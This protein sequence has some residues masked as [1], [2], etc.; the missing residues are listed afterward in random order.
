MEI[1]QQILYNK[2]CIQISFLKNEVFLLYNLYMLR[3]FKINT[4]L[5]ALITALMA[6]PMCYSASV[7]ARALQMRSPGRDQVI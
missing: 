2:F 7:K 3:S 6:V 5:M 1:R 4:A